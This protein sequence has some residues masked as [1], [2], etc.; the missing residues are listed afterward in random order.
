MAIVTDSPV[1]AVFSCLFPQGPC[2]LKWW[3]LKMFVYN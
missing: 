3:E 1:C 2:L